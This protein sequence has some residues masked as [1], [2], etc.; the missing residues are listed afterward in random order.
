MQATEIHGESVVIS[1]NDELAHYLEELTGAYLAAGPE[2]EELLLSRS[3]VLGRYITG[4]HTEGIE[5]QRDAIRLEVPESDN[6]F[7][8]G[9]NRRFEISCPWD[10]ILRGISMPLT[11]ACAAGGAKVLVDLLKL[12]VEDRKGRK[13]TIRHGDDEIEL[14]GGMSDHDLERAVK[15]FERR[16]GQSK[17]LRP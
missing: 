11:L 9:R 10:V 2:W 7:G 14:A 4:A 16:F 5:A 12:W 8:G 6:Q 15:L 13:V 17:I 1:G 3:P